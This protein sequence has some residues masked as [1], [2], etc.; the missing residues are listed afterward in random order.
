MWTR[1]LIPED[2]EDWKL[3]KRE[4]RFWRTQFLTGHGVFNSFRHRI[5]KAASDECCYHKGVADTVE[6][7]L[8][9]CNR[10][11]EERGKCYRKL[12][13]EL[14]NRELKKIWEA[15]DKDEETWRAFGDF[16]KEILTEKTKEERRREQEGEDSEAMRLSEEDLESW[17]PG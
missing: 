7:T 13:L 17:D 10:W 4:L 11:N 8:I 5:G 9:N 3:K 15:A 16:C 12:G 14:E 6:H 2:P 1:K